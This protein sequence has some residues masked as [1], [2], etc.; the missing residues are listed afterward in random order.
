MASRFQRGFVLL[1]RGG[2]QGLLC[3][4]IPLLEPVNDWLDSGRQFT[5]PGIRLQ[6]D[7]NDTV[8]VAR[9]I[10]MKSAVPDQLR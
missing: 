10:D 7:G 1:L 2:L 6:L 3:R 9:V 8:C 4:L 5:L